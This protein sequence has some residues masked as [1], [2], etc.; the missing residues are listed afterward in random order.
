MQEKLFR[1]MQGRYGVDQLSKFLVVLGIIIVVLS[2]FIRGNIV[3]PIGM[4]VIIIA[5]FRALSKDHA[6]RY[7]E[8]QKYLIYENKV[9]SFFR[10]GKFNTQQS[11]THHVYTCP[12]CKQKIRVPRGKGKIE[13]SCPKCYTKFMKKS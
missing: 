5:Y 7:K 2:N 12:N 10:K 13:V 8:N 4:V 3:Y 9:K 6:R 11:K 1:F